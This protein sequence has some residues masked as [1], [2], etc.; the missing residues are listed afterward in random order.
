MV[1]VGTRVIGID[2]GERRIGVS[3]SDSKRILAMPHC[4]ITR[5]GDAEADRRAI[6]AL[7]S[8]LDA[9]LVV[10][11]LPLTMS[12]QKG[13]AAAAAEVEAAAIAAAL[14]VPMVLYDERLTT[15]EAERRRRLPSDAVKGRGAASAR[16]QESSRAGS[17]ARRESIDAAAATVLLQSWLDGHRGQV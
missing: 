1:A 6:A 16:R 12:G 9:G 5:S 8:E 13:T 2:L 17:R 11:G 3:L 4:V 7:A 10:I 14:D 15:V